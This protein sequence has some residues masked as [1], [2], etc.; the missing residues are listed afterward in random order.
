[1]TLPPQA[2]PETV[3]RRRQDAGQRNEYGEFLRAKVTETPLRA[4]I[5]PLG[6]EVEYDL[7]APLP[8]PVARLK[9]YVRGPD[10][11]SAAGQDQPADTV[12]VD[13]VVYIVVES[14][15]WPGSHT[16]A[17]LQ[18]TGGPS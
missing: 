6:L 2:F 16:V 5:E 17:T 13:G 11:V 18:R 4:S 10:A 14:R 15:S 9:A 7:R 3:V 1:M 8:S 12:L